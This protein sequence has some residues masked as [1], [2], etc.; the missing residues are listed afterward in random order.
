D[1]WAVLNADDPR[2]ASFGVSCRGHVLY[3][4]CGD[5]ADLRAV[6]LQPGES[7][8]YFFRLAPL[9]PPVI[10]PGGATWKGQRAAAPRT[11]LPSYVRFHLPL[12]GRHNVCNVL[13]ALGVACLFGIEPPA[14]AEAVS[15]LRPASQR[16]EVV[17]LANGV[18]VVDDCYNS[19]PAALEAM[20]GAVAE[21][22]ARRRYAV[23]GGMMELGPR[24]EQL[25]HRCGRR[26][27]EL[28]FAGLITVGNEARPLSAG[29]LAAGLPDAAIE[30]CA[31]PEEA[32]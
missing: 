27:A 11:N 25:H 32:G 6:E 16:G 4:G 5:S 20:L 18:L 2:V 8:G 31:T 21:I 14:L 22:P 29:A 23:L 17:R 28:R 24:S 9:T 30:Q 10:R 3:Y 19:S 7:G 15:Q 12:L 26:V 13:A 1:D